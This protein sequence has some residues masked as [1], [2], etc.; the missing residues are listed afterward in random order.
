MSLP[1]IPIGLTFDDVLLLPGESRVHPAEVS[2]QSRLTRAIGLNI[3]II[4]AAMDTVTES[5]LAIAIAQQGGLGVIHKN[6]SIESQAAEVDMVKRYESGM[7]VDP[8]TV[9]PEQQVLEALDLMERYRISGLPVVD[10]KGKLVGILTNR[11]LR[12]ETNKDRLIR[13]VMTSGNLVT[14]PQGTTLEQAKELLHKH[15]IEKLPVV[16]N[17][18]FLKGLITVKDIQKKLEFPTSCKDQQ[19]RLRV[20]A[21]IGVSQD[22]LDRAAALMDA[23]VDCIV[24]DSSHAHS[25]GVL[26]LVGKFR[27]VYPSFPLIAGNVATYEGAK[28]LCELGV[29]GIKIGIGPGS[30]CTT[31]V[32]TGGGVPQLTAISECRRA[33]EGRDVT[34]I[35]DGGIKFS[36]DIVKAIASGANVVMI[37]S[38]FAGAEESPGEVILYKGRAFKSYR[39]MGSIGAMK[40]GSKDR[41]FQESSE[42]AKLVPEGVEGQ[43]PYK[44][45]LASIIHQMIGGLRAGMG[46]SGCASIEEL[47]T[48][49]RFI[50]ITFAGLRESHVH[51]VTI[52]KESPNYQSE[53]WLSGGKD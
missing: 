42:L 6:L 34:L 30:I 23:K 48:R 20:A 16:D 47:R 22:A 49:A 35:A 37:G 40:I 14:V 29:D 53:S 12:F 13:E 10:D 36:G 51:D 28:A 24:I 46:L 39:G 45:S 38:L 5:R 1:S 8:V 26:D 32:V 7:I 21:A 18:G 11:D 44:G 43:V 19:G 4:S 41:Y 50:Q 25:K 27:N 33:V 15:K 31:R 52:T 3:P 17:R 2:V 9:R